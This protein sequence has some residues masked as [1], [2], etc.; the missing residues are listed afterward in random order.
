MKLNP[1]VKT[2]DSQFLVALFSNEISSKLQILGVFSEKVPR[3]KKRRY[4]TVFGIR[5]RCLEKLN[6]PITVSVHGRVKRDS[7]MSTPFSVYWYVP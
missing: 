6:M 2:Q 4:F 1:T 7:V 5:Y 3:I